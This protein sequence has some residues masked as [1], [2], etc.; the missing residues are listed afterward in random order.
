MKPVFELTALSS[1]DDESENDDND[2]GIDD[3]TDENDHGNADNT[4]ELG[5]YHDDLIDEV[6]GQ[7][8]DKNL[9]N[10]LAENFSDFLVLISLGTL[11]SQNSQTIFQLTMQVHLNIFLCIL[12]MKC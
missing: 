7:Q 4:D 9:L 2:D 5:D 6:I 10:W 3:N 12:Q 8:L 1:S 11:M